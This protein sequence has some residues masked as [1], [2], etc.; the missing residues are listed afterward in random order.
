MEFYLCFWEYVATPLKDCLNDAYQCGEMSISQKRGVISLLPKKNKDPLLLKNWRPITLLNVDYK[1]AT[2]CIA[3]RLEKVLPEVINRDQTGYVKNRFIGENIRLISDVMEFYEKKNLPGM[4]LFIDFEK[5]FDSLE[6]NYLFKVL[7]VMNFGPMFR[8][9]IHTFYTNITSCVMNNGYASDFFQLYRGVRQGC[10]LSGLLFVLAIEVLAQAIRQNEN[11][12]GLRINETELKLS[13]Y[14]DD[15]TAF[16][17]DECSANHLF[18]LLDDFGACSGLKINISKTEGMWLGSLKRHLGK[19][20][21]FHIAW[22]EEYVF[23]LGVAFAYDSNTSYRI[24]FEEK[25]VTL[26]KVLNQWTTRNLTLIGRICIVKTLAISKLVY[27]ASVLTVPPNFAEK[28][29]DICFKFIWNFK[30]DKVKRH[31]IIGPV[32]KGGLNMV[33]FTMVVKSLKAAWVK[34]LCEADGS[35]WCSL[36]SSATSQY[37]GRAIFDC[38]FDIRDLNLAPHVPKFYRDILTVW[39]E[40]HSKN[41][42][43]G[44]DYQHEIIWNNRFIRIDG[45]PV[46]YSSWYKKGIFKIQHLLNENR[47][48]LSRFEFQQRYGL[49]VNFLT[50]SGLLSAIPDAWKRSILNSEE[51]HNNSDEHNLT[52]LNVTAKIARK[53]LVLETHKPSNIERKL[54]EQNLPVKAIYELPFKVTMENKLRCFQYKVIHNILPTNYKLYKMKLKTSPSCDRCGNPYENLLHLLYECPRTQTFWQLVIAWWNK[55]RSETVVLNA[56]DILYGYKPESNF[57]QALNHFVIIAKYHIFL[58]W[59]NKASPSF[60]IFSLLLNEKIRCERTIAFKNNTLTNFRAKWTT[61]A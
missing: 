14:A 56:T 55:K 5:A 9:W 32:D 11:I 53:M 35:K 58:S 18:K 57:F 46:F 3:M 39:Q 31:T 45:K 26:K 17:K 43:T 23:A 42:S 12:H 22:P 15:L 38:N 50:Y 7:E 40:L 4:L 61:L 2:K 49:S 60:E 30:P 48:F 8:K 33:D 25:L 47:N 16:I 21:P 10:P 52:S 1:I 27:N 51:T 29:N 34:R 54:D 24:N 44:D 41:P 13:M 28:V 6:W 37:G 20:A 59:L 36:F 19:L